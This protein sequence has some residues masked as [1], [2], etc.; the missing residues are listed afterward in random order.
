MKK[1]VIAIVAL[2]AV[3]AGTLS[4]ASAAGCSTFWGMIACSGQ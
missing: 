3:S 1:L 2:A 4:P